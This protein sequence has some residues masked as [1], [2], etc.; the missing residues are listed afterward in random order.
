[1]A[2]KLSSFFIKCLAV[3]GFAP[4]PSPGVL[5]LNLNPAGGLSSPGLPIVH[6]PMLTK[7]LCFEIDNEGVKVDIEGGGLA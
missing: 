6:P 1:M 7:N 2:P 4:K 3:R 5:S